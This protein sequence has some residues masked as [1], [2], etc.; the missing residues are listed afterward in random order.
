MTRPLALGERKVLVMVYTRD[1]LARG[2]LVLMENLRASIWLRTQ[3][4]PNHI[5]L[6]S[7][8]IIQFNGTPPQPQ[9]FAEVFVPTAEVIA[10]HLDP[11]V[12]EPPDFDETET[13]RMMVTVRALIGPFHLHGK[14]RVSTQTDIATALDVAHTTWMSVYGAVLTSPYLPKFHTQSPLVLVNPSRVAFGLA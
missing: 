7:P 12:K 9:S 11:S 2:E 6:H 8:N 3:G 1:M 4:V 13:N 5:H 10:F 14:L